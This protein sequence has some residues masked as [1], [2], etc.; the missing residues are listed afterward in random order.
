MGFPVWFGNQ[1]LYCTKITTL[2][3]ATLV[4]CY[5][6]I[7]CIILVTVACIY[8]LHTVSPGKATNLTL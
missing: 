4:N 8:I 6:S 7:S 5:A 1:N 2:N 3:P